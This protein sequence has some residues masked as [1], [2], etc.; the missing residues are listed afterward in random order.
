M[1]IDWFVA[2]VWSDPFCNPELCYSHCALERATWH[3]QGGQT[4]WT[5]H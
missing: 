5:F 2:I 3:T 4:F 1:S